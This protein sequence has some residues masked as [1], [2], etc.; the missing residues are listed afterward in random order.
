MSKTNSY[1]FVVDT[2][3]ASRLDSSTLDEVGRNLWP[4]DCQSCG[5]ALGTELPALVVRDIGG[6]TAAANLNHVRCHSPEW[7][8]R[9]VFGLRSENFLSYRTFGCAIVGE[10]GGK[11]KPL[12]F[13]FVNPSLEQ[14][15]LH[16]AGSGWEIGTM[17]NYRDY[18]GLTGLV[19][20]AH[21][22]AASALHQR[23]LSG[24][25]ATFIHALEVGVVGSLDLFLGHPMLRGS[26]R[27]SVTNYLPSCC[28]RC[29]HPRVARYGPHYFPSLL[30]GVTFSVAG[31]LEN[32]LG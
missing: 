6:I 22:K 23:L 5:R 15:M 32:Q 7:V 14:V 17:R 9:G 27:G 16:N 24:V 1:P 12:P 10:S 13:G 2:S 21:S 20:V 29:L 19:G 11:P 31:S 30:Q 28:E 4:V 8:D 25:P 18:H 26:W 3:I